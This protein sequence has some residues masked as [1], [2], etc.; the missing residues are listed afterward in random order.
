MQRGREET[1][2]SEKNGVRLT[3]PAAGG[4]DRKIIQTLNQRA[5]AV[6]DCEHYSMLGYFN[7]YFETV[8]Y[9]YAALKT[10][11]EII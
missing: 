5:V 10:P 1:P 6:V 3:K 9:R 7:Q 11:E 4:N 2:K 8:V